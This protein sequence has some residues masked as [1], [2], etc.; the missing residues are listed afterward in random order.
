M[1]RQFFCVAGSV[2]L[3]LAGAA[4]I[5]ACQGADAP[6]KPVAQTDPAGEEAPGPLLQDHIRFR[7]TVSYE[8]KPDLK[9]LAALDRLVTES[10]SSARRVESI[11]RGIWL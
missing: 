7:F 9:P 6:P 5:P 4:S 1:L 10:A 3:F 2:A 11:G 8:S